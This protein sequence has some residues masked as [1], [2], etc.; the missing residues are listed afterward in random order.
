MLKSHGLTL[1][2]ILGIASQALA[3]QSEQSLK[4]RSE[5]KAQPQATATPAAQPSTLPQDVSGMYAFLKEGEYLQLAIANGQLEGV[6]S[7]YG[8]SQSDKG[9]F[10]DLLFD[11]TS[12]GGETLA[13]STK[14]V[15]GTWVEF[16]GT[17][18]RGSAKKR[19][20]EGYY[21]L[22]GTLVMNTT[23][24]EGKVQPMQRDVSFKSFPEDF[25]K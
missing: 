3:G 19:S 23:G 10:E 24:P 11:K 21:L 14:H 12:L 1:V 20:D 4:R 5:Q 7:I 2:L 8:E 16:T 13:F 9:E 22:N 18:V 6:V 15:H 17:I 25:G